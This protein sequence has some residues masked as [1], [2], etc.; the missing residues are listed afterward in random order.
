MSAV[1]WFGILTLL[2]CAGAAARAQELRVQGGN[3]LLQI[4]TAL[5]GQEPAPV[6]NSATTLRYR[7]QAQISKITIS[8]SC[9]GQRFTL[10]ARVTSAQEG[11]P[12]PTVTLMHGMP[13]ADLI[14]DIPLE[15]ASPPF[16]RATVE[17]TASATFEQGNSTELGTDTHVITFTILAQ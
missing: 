14:R 16:R 7:R 6:V 4:T 1:R 12:A 2:L 5:P 11:V 9:P 15:G 8:T 13:A 10:Q 3:Q 17:Y